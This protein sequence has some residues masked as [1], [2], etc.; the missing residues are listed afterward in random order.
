MNERQFLESFRLT[1]EGQKL[2]QT[3][4]YAEGTAGPQG[5]QT[6][7]GGGTFSD[8]SKHPDTV[9]SKGRL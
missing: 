2:L 4:R 6:L 8:L 5:Y 3:I 1:P 7:F 9:I